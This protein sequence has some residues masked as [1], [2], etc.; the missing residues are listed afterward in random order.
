MEWPAILMILR[1][2]INILNTGCMFFDQVDRYLSPLALVATNCNGFHYLPLIQL[3]DLNTRQMKRVSYDIAQMGYQQGLQ[4][5][6]AK[7]LLFRLQ[8]K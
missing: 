4:F 6:H 7:L 1:C 3:I 8:Q 5:V 2:K